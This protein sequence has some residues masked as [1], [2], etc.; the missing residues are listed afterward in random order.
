MNA[1]N[2]GLLLLAVV[3][4]VGSVLIGSRREGVEFAGSDGQA[5]EAVTAIRPDYQ[6]WFGCS[7]SPP[8]LG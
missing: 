3:L 1:R 5:M 2:G 4:M 7:R 6:P 8:L